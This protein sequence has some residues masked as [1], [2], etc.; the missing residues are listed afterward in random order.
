[1]HSVGNRRIR[2]PVAVAAFLTVV[3]AA[4]GSSS[5]VDIQ[6]LGLGVEA[7][8]QAG[9]RLELAVPLQ[10]DTTI[11]VAFAPA[12]VTAAIS[13]A[14]DGDS[15]LLSVAV[16]ADTPRGAYNLALLVDQDG[17]SYEVGWPFEVVEPVGTATTVAGSVE[18]VLTVESPQVG[19]VISS[20]IAVRGTSSTGQVGYLLAGSDD[21]VLAEGTIDVL[22]ETFSVTVDF[23]NT[24]CTEM[25]LEVFH[26]NEGGLSLTIPLTHPES[27]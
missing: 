3:V 9:S 14:A 5:T 26:P 12:G 4:C 8:I 23:V 27:G 22:D 7:D 1:M 24:C 6:S 15:L 20:P 17:E 25:R 11:Q 2:R 13:E 16:D 10:P 18:A 19:D 21:T